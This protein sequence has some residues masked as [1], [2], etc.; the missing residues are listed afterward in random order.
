M[1]GIPMGREGVNMCNLVLTVRGINL[2][3]EWWSYRFITL[4]YWTF[5]RCKVRDDGR[6]GAITT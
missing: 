5:T 4:F 3:K 6:G 1:W 2:G